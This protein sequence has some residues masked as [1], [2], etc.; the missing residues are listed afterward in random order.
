MNKMRTPVDR[1]EWLYRRSYSNPEHKYMNP[2][3]SANSR[4]FK[5]R[6]KDKSE[7]SVDV[8]SMTIPEAAVL[9][10]SKFMLFEIANEEVINIGLVTE[11]DPLIDNPAYAVVL[12]MAEEDDILPGLLARKAR[13][14][15][16]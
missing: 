11:H 12:G 8:K 4:V 7:L 1:Q 13:R 5:L 6:E 15:P 3:G 14:V 2:D 9:D 16:F 10:A